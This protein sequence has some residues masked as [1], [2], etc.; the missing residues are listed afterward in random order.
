M[1]EEFININLTYNQFR[2]LN[3][4]ILNLE[5]CEQLLEKYLK[6]P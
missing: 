3:I 1:K 6:I 2:A 4:Q 5:T